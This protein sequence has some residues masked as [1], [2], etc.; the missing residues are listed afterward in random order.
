MTTDVFGTM[1]MCTHFLYTIY[2]SCT[3]T[4]LHMYMYVAC[5]HVHVGISIVDADIT[6]DILEP[7]DFSRFVS[8]LPGVAY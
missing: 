5:V 4:F 7:A 6:T 2:M 1:E 3:F 8:A